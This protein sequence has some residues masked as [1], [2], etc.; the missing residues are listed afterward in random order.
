M[1]FLSKSRATPLFVN[2]SQKQKYDCSPCVSA[3]AI[4]DKAAD[5]WNIFGRLSTLPSTD[6]AARQL[7]EACMN[8]VEYNYKP[9]S[10][11]PV[12]GG[13]KRPLT[14]SNGPNSLTVGDGT[15]T[16]GNDSAFTQ[17]VH[18]IESAK[19]LLSSESES[20]DRD[21][22]VLT[23][24]S[25]KRRRPNRCRILIDSDDSDDSTSDCDRKACKTSFSRCSVNSE[26]LQNKVEAKTNIQRLSGLEHRHCFDLLLNHD[27]HDAVTNS[28]IVQSSQ[29]SLDQPP[30]RSD[31]YRHS[32][33]NYSHSPSESVAD[34]VDILRVSSQCSVRLHKL[35]LH[36][37]PRRILLSQE[38]KLSLSGR[39]SLAESCK[40]SMINRDNQ[41]SASSDLV[42]VS[43]VA[44]NDNSVNESSNVQY[45]S[46]DELFSDNELLESVC[47]SPSHY[48][49]TDEHKGDT[50]GE[51]L[52]STA[53][54]KQP[55]VPFVS[56]SQA[57]D[58]CILIDDSDD[59]LFANLTQNDMTIKDECDSADD[60]TW[61]QDDVDCATAA[62]SGNDTAE[63]P[64][65]LEVCDPWVDDVADVSSDELD[66]AYD[67]AMSH[68][69]RND[70][71]V[72]AA[73]RQQ[74]HH[75]DDAVNLSDASLSLANHCTTSTC[76]VLLKPLRVSDIPSEIMRLS[77][78]QKHECE[79]DV[80]VADDETAVDSHSETVDDSH[81][82][83]VVDSPSET[84]GDS[85]VDGGGDYHSAMLSES[86]MRKS[87]SCKVNSAIYG[88][89]DTGLPSRADVHRTLDAAL[90]FPDLREFL[91]CE[92][93]ASSE[94]SAKPVIEADADV[95][96][97][98]KDTVFDEWCQTSSRC[99]VLENVDDRLSADDT[100]KMTPNVDVKHKRDNRST[101][102]R[103]ALESC[104]EVAEFYGTRASKENKQY[105]RESTEGKGLPKM[106]KAADTKHKAATGLSWPK[107][108]WL[109][110]TTAAP[111]HVKSQKVADGVCEEKEWK[112]K[113]L[114]ST[115]RNVSSAQCQK[116]AQMRDRGKQKL[117]RDKTGSA[118]GKQ[119]QCDDNND[120]FFGLSQFSVAKQQLVERNRQLKAN[121]QC[122]C[123]ICIALKLLLNV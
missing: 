41:L 70:G 66:E 6:V 2:S 109:H 77:Q 55:E 29:R 34:K 19:S 30:R 94:T 74:F 50:A 15:K 92:K 69:H 121:G 23:S 78:E 13:Q 56:Y 106:D 28:D 1:S 98:V 110:V 105:K 58:D 84:V 26:L 38:D 86:V 4:S 118:S 45:C 88:S 80:L 53:K 18:I 61:M 60:D 79:A 122:H 82:E 63:T 91:D 119:L 123:C 43:E 99:G 9:D 44:V 47:L 51:C 42:C 20:S 25:V 120:R 21:S 112:H 36:D 97:S 33:D 62:V 65:T 48:C 102:S 32:I 52:E 37:V 27:S 35:Q 17:R 71:R 59:D 72:S 83:T 7:S 57:D 114:P 115:G 22:P 12:F 49:N 24:R 111:L 113:L 104:V 14:S 10:F 68:A 67:A 8:D 76:T 16:Y 107:K 108:D 11:S 54:C 81:S 85:L 95:L 100:N 73:V 87:V 116:I 64:V 89:G 90:K 101:S 39:C 75:S 5:Q 31:L 93:L 96:E 103:S 117:R 40:V 46:S 3:A